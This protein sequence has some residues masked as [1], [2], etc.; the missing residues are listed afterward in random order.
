LRD[1]Y[2]LVLAKDPDGLGAEVATLE[3]EAKN[4]AARRQAAKAAKD[5]DGVRA[6]EAEAE[7][8]SQRA[9]DLEPRIRAKTPERLARVK[10]L[11]GLRDS[12]E[13]FQKLSIEALERVVAKAP[14]LDLMK[15]QLLEELLGS[16]MASAAVREAAAG[17]AAVKAAEAASATIEYI[18]GHLIKDAEGQLFTDGIL[19]FRQG[20]RWHVVAVFESKAGRASAQKLKRAWKDFPHPE[21]ADLP[22]WKSMPDT[23]LRKL[24]DSTVS[25]DRELGRK[26]RQWRTVRSEA[27][28][29]LRETVDEMANVHSSVLEAKY[30][31][32]ITELMDVLPKSETGQAR[33]SLER[34]LPQHGSESTGIRIGRPQADGSVLFEE[35]RLTS[36]TGSPGTTKLVG[37]VP[38]D[39]RGRNLKKIAEHQQIRF[40]LMNDL[41]VTE[42]QLRAA[43]EALAAAATAAP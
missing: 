33:K 11:T 15:G 13:L 34:L 8:L 19:A 38:G 32:R 3:A 20:D 4:I 39:V 16:R 30:A 21:P 43:S 29:E 22:R 14:H 28:E 18:P 35:G 5:A 2:A 12:S 24:L 23:E 26:I 6:A 42:P 1:K 9:R 37:V 27:I 41:G 17:P 25:A 36:V 10:W 31:D 7:K 40:E